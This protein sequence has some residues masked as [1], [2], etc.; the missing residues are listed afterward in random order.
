MRLETSNH[1]LYFKPFALNLD[2]K[3]LKKYKN[4]L[5]SLTKMWLKKGLTM[6]IQKIRNFILITKKSKILSKK[7]IKVTFW[8]LTVYFK[9]K[10]NSLK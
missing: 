10:K 7:K 3:F 8:D 1:I 4:T 9:F 5:K 6:E 2:N